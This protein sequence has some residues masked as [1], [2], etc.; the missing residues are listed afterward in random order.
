M[1][2]SKLK[3]KLEDGRTVKFVVNYKYHLT[4]T[5]KRL[6]KFLVGMKVEDNVEFGKSY[7]FSKVKRAETIESTEDIM[8]VRIHSKIVDWTKTYWEKS[9][10]EINDIEVLTD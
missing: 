10:V 8:K 5:D 9:T 6:I 2:K 7:G 4:A 3:A 1:K